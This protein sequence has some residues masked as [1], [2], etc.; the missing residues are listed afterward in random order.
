[1]TDRNVCHFGLF[2]VFY[3]LNNQKNQNFE[4]LKKTPGDKYAILLYML[5]CYTYMIIYMLYC[6]WD[7]APDRCNYFSFWTILYPFTPLTAQKI[8]IKKKLKKK[9]KKTPGDIIILHKCTKNHDHMLY[10]SWDMACDK[11][12][13][14]SLYPLNSPKNQNLKKMKKMHGD[15]IISHM[16]T[17]NHDQMMYHSWGMVH[18]EWTQMDRKSDIKRWVSHLKN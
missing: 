17:K 14:F 11:S 9:K 13:Y 6:S 18:N 4:K 7:M 8:K 3:P 5:Y 16:C 12:N 2:F 10:C 1:M 15:N